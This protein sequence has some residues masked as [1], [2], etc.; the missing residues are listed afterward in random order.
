MLELFG[1]RFGK[2]VTDCTVAA[3]SGA[4]TV[5]LTIQTSRQSAHDETRLPGRLFMPEVLGLLLPI[6]KMKVHR[7][8]L[9]GPSVLTVFAS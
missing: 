2:R 7:R 5:M 9:W 3:G 8:Q 4:T 6:L 1:Y